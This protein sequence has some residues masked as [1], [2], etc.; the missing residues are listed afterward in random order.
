MQLD[1]TLDRC[2]R[3]EERAAAVY[4]SYATSARTDPPLCALWTTLAREEEAHARAL[5]TAH[6]NLASLAD[7]QT[8]LDGWE[9]ALREVELC[10]SVAEAL[11]PAA[12][13]KQQLSAALDLELTE[14]EALRHFLLAVSNEPD[15]DSTANHAA[16]LAE[17]AAHL[18][19]DPHVRLQA[20]LLLARARVRSL[21]SEE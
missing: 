13:M 18:S 19:T 4:R 21:R 12:T 3:L 8:R 6:S 17:R 11:G 1:V 9:E 16:L 15:V 5:A 7:R 2:R 10:L 20:A 14:F